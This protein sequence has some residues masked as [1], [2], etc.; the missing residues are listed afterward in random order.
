LRKTEGVVAKAM[1]A[2][3]KVDIFN[4]CKKIIIESTGGCKGRF[5]IDDSGCGRSPDRKRRWRQ[6]TE[7]L[8]MEALKATSAEVIVNSGRFKKMVGTND[9]AAINMIFIREMVNNMAK[10][11]RIQLDIIVEQTNIIEGRVSN[12]LIDG[13][14]EA[15]IGGEM[16]ALM[17]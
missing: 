7:S 5:E 12:S 4:V 1:K 8:V 10:P 13:G 11:Q 16:E 15:K 14:R 2:K 9:G 17:I 3:A 6:A